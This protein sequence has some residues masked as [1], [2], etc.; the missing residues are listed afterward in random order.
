MNSSYGGGN[1]IVSSNVCNDYVLA[2]AKHG[3]HI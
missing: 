2:N 1:N 3:S